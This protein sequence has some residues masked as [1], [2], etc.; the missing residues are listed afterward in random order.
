M[1][2]WEDWFL[3]AWIVFCFGA[4]ALVLWFDRSR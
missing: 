1:S 2:T 3:L 4:V